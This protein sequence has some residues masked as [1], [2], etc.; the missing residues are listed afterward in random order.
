MSE[1][2]EIRSLPQLDA[3]LTA[4]TKR[5]DLLIKQTP[6]AN[7]FQGI[8]RQLE[9]IRGFVRARRVPSEEDR[10]RIIMGVQAD[11]EINDWDHPFAVQLMEI[12]YAF[13]HWE[14]LQI[15]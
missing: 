10:R 13:R 2:N 7:L 11:R 3:A 8:K 9:F 5:V 4:A 14:E 12:D 15:K 1:D 6:E